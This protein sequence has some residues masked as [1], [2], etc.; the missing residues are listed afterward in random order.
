ME[1]NR[2]EAAEAIAQLRYMQNVYSQQYEFIQNEISAYIAEL[3]ALRGNLSII[4]NAP[5][6][7]N[8]KVLVDCDGGAYVEAS[9]GKVQKMIV[10]VG[11]GYL[12]EKSLEDAK[13]FV[14]EN[15]ARREEMIRRLDGEKKKL[16]SE[17][18]NIA[19]KLA[20]MQQ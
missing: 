14:N 20:S 18:V 2:N 4:E 13:R 15:S 11:A 17:L 10:Y 3:N 5:T 16:E 7:D 19:Y 8:S 1:A 6:L 12:V 9:L